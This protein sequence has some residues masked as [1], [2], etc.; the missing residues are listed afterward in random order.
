M[1]KQQYVG[2][3]GPSTTVV[4]RSMLGTYLYYTFDGDTCTVGRTDNCSK[5]Q[6][7]I[8]LKDPSNGAVYI[9]T[10]HP[11]STFKADSSNAH[12]YKFTFGGAPFE[13][14]FTGLGNRDEINILYDDGTSYSYKN[15]GKTTKTT[16]GTT[17]YSWKA[18][19]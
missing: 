17:T 1:E 13:V 2:T 9:G 8:G 19:Y 4:E 15:K 11:D 6:H 7:I 16:P 14:S 12:K 10:T 3:T 18:I 5:K